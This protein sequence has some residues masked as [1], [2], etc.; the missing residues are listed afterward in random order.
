MISINLGLFN[1]LPIPAL[2]GCKLLF[3]ACMAVTRK[4]IPA[5]VEGI[6]SAVGMAVL[7]LL[8]VLISAHDI[9]R[10]FGHG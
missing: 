3:I 8:M 2:D 4:K 10:L 1:L 6:I 9:W 7:L 5:K